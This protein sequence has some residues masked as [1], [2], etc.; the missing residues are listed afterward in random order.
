[1][2]V[3]EVSSESVTF[4]ALSDTSKVAHWLR[5]EEAV[6][7]WRP[8]DATHTEVTWTLRYR[9]NLDPAWYFEPW[10]RYATGLAA[11]YLIDNVVTPAEKP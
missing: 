3:A 4:R 10:E 8:L 6:V 2:E 11:D 9:R 7:S 5:W 1:M